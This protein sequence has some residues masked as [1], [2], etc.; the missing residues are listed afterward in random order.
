[1]FLHSKI[2]KEWGK[3][4]EVTYLVLDCKL[5]KIEE[6]PN[7]VDLEFGIGSGEWGH[8][9]VGFELWSYSTIEPAKIK[10]GLILGMAV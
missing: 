3:G 10:F 1:M 9:R 4:E 5:T 6:A 2:T 8:W 7:L